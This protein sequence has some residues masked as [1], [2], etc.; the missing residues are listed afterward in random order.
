M[1]VNIGEA[2][3]ALSRLV[4]RA[5]A[6][7]DIV[8]ARDGRPVARLVPIGAS[9]RGRTVVGCLGGSVTFAPGYRDGETAADWSAENG[10]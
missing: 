2:R 5:E 4:A 1:Q 6:G 10:G 8:L 9:P 3:N 7:E